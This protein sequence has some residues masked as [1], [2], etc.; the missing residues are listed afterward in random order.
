M[1]AFGGMLAVILP[2]ASSVFLRGW[3]VVR[4]LMITLLCAD[5]LAGWIWAYKS[6]LDQ[7]AREDSAAF[8]MAIDPLCKSTSGK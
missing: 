1:S 2:V 3:L 8:A 7:S 6:L 4:W 5:A